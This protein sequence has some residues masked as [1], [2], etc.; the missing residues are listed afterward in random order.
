MSGSLRRSVRF[1]LAPRSG[2]LWDWPFCDFGGKGRSDRHSC[3]SDSF[4]KQVKTGKNACLLEFGHFHCRLAA[5]EGRPAF[6]G[7]SRQ[8]H[9]I[10]RRRA[11]DEIANPN[12]G[13]GF[14]RRWRGAA[15]RRGHQGTALK[16][17]PTVK[18]RDAAAKPAFR[19][20]AN[21]TF[22]QNACFMVG[23]S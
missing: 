22:P 9:P 23:T 6:Q 7:R 17:R 11:T 3:L 13:A 15:S 1:S 10:P 16:G 21:L 14:K 19:C 12:G 8:S 4:L 20:P 18:R 5:S 2:R